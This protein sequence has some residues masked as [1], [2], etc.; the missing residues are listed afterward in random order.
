MREL[1]WG[2]FVR[3]GKIVLMHKKI[4]DSFMGSSI[5]WRYIS[6]NRKELTVLTW[7]GVFSAL[8]NGTVPYIAGK[9]FDAIVKPSTITVVGID[10]ALWMAILSIWGMFQILALGVDWV[11]DVRNEKF[12][13]NI[14][15]DYKATAFSRLLLLSTEFHK[16]RKM[17]EVMEGI[18]RAGNGLYSIVGRVVVDLAPKFLSIVV[19]V[20]FAFYMNK[21][22]AT[23]LLL[24]V[25]M[26]IFVLART[27][28]RAIPLQRK[29]FKLWQKAYGAS[30]EAV[31]NFAM[32]KQFAAEFFE[33]AK[34]RKKFDNAIFADF[35]LER[36]WT[37]IR[38]SSRTIVFVVQLI[39]FILSVFS[40]QAGAMSLGELLAFNAYS[41]MVFG[42]FAILGQ[43]WQT[44]QNG[45]VALERAETI[46][47]GPA[48][49]Y[50]PE[51]SVEPKVTHGAIEFKNV[52]F[53][54]KK[55][56]KVLQGV[57]F[58]ASPGQMVALVGESGSGK[59]TL[60]D[61]VSAYY[62]PAKGEVLVDGIPTN[63]WK[64]KNLREMIAI[65]PQ[66]VSLFNE[67]LEKNLSYGPRRNTKTAIVK[68]VHD[69]HADEFIE[70][71]PKKYEQIVGERGIKLSVGQKQRIAIA[72][73]ILRNPKI[74]ILD[75]PTSA[76]DSET[77]KFVTE[78]LDRVMEGRTTF[79]IAH[80]LSTVR[81][82]D[83]ILVLDSGKII[84]SGTHDELMKIKNGNYRRRYE[85][86]V[87]LV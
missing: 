83:K 4:T 34:I 75:E 64:L 1:V 51:G 57:S 67:T 68:A 66:E 32:V 74:L 15:A 58:T 18:N 56:N 20:G 5:A 81:K 44:L 70:K 71:F 49:D 26:Y 65:V 69:A 35:T 38:F 59:S 33:K 29:T 80:R 45:L 3:C 41:A 52:S 36:I 42:P 54:Y 17:G 76:L 86:H 27:V 22:L 25:A 30:H 82:A 11:W 31:N 48:E 37:N 62:F 46:L 16:G 23:V 72:R 78:A 47:G 21:S 39:I 8:A 50:E 77:E 87:G 10:I 28:P 53:A 9:F 63:K 14:L 7:L 12:S 61:L 6:A 2:V 60:I 24:G 40:I 84:E 13:M 85:L 55:G 73:A 19:G 79:V 43:N